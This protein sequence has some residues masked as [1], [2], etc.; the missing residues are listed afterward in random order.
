M[1]KRPDSEK[2]DKNTMSYSKTMSI[3]QYLRD[4]AIECLCTSLNS[5]KPLRVLKLAL[6]D[7]FKTNILFSGYQIDK[8]CVKAVCTKLSSRLYIVEATHRELTLISNNGILAL[9]QIAANL[10]HINA[11]QEGV[12]Q[13]YHQKIFSPPSLL[14]QVI[15][16]QF[17]RMLISSTY[18]VYQD[19]MN[20]LISITTKA[21]LSV[22]ETDAGGVAD[23]LANKNKFKYKF[24]ED[25]IV[26]VLEMVALNLNGETEMNDF[27]LRLLEVFC[28]IS[29]K[30]KETNDKLL[31][32]SVK[33]S[34]LCL[35]KG[36]P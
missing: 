34:W 21:I 6:G 2:I 4:T 29:V 10:S 28:Q 16:E 36:Q 32:N 33:V 19:I 11:I 13:I 3:F 9:S 23:T 18:S 7:N 30:I 25:K 31:K 17:G 35:G 5:C 26:A 8:E 24:V 27:L 1:S 12:L 14:D 15:I 20:T 22:Y